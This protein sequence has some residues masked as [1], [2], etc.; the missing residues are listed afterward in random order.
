MRSGCSS[1]NRTDYQA[2]WLTALIVLGACQGFQSQHPQDAA[3][4]DSSTADHQ[5][6]DSGGRDDG[7]LTDATVA[8]PRTPPDA[9]SDIG[10]TTKPTA[11]AALPLVGGACCKKGG[12]QCTASRC[13]AEQLGPAFCSANCIPSPDTCPVGFIC[14]ISLRLCRPLDRADFECGQHV[15]YA[16]PQPFGGCC[17][18]RADCKSFVCNTDRPSGRLAFCTTACV[19]PGDCPSGYT[20]TN[21]RCAPI[22][23]PP[24]CKYY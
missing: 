17:A 11:D 15:A 19:Q 2:A 18:K 24:T 10:G 22:G 3:P 12:P 8:G 21:K 6:H 9:A 13:V 1:G 5:L 20:C 7:A 23:T 4:R 16:G 14:D